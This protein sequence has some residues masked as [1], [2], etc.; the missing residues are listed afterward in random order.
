MKQGMIV[1]FLALTPLLRG[2]GQSLLIP[3]DDSQKNH[4]KAYGLAFLALKNGES[5]DWLLNYRGGSFLLR[6]NPKMLDEGM[7]RGISVQLLQDH[8]VNAILREITQPEVNM[9]VVKLERAPRI[10]VYS[11]KNGLI[12][13]ETDAVITVLDYAEIPYTI[14]YD[15]EVLHDHL[16]R[17]DWLHLHH[18]DF[19]GQY[20]RFLRRE[21]AALEMELQK[22]TA[23]QF[24]YAKVSAMKLDVARK[25]KTFCAGGGYLFAMCSGAETFDIALAAEGIDI[26]ES[27]YDGDDA[28]EDA[29]A[30]LD[31]TKTLAFHN[32]SLEPGNSRKFSDIN[33]G[34]PDFFELEKD[35]FTLFDFSAKWDLIPAILNQ[36]HRHMIKE[37]MGQTSGFSKFTVKHEATILGENSRSG[38]VRY[39]YGEL[40]KGHW[41]FYSG[42]DPEGSPGRRRQ[43]TDLNLYPHSPGYRLILNNVLFPSARKKKQKT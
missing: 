37:F 40:G 34:R 29:Q 5:I 18:E 19:T 38:N 31:F 13:D 43:P 15:E 25:I 9:T 20:G 14:L 36:N 1:L 21:S 8:E 24:G 35:Y 39:I 26:N 11:P 7:V 3:M 10:A 22:T 41:T 17:Y 16:A 32:F 23:A 30:R 6:Y 12:A 28:D 27:M 33:T 42:H 4:L 2:A